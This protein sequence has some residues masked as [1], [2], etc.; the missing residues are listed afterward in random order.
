[1]QKSLSLVQSAEQP[2]LTTL[3]SCHEFVSI[4]EA[5]V[6]DL[7]SAPS[8]PKI[9][10][11]KLCSW[12]NWSSETWAEVSWVNSLWLLTAERPCI[13]CDKF[14]SCEKCGRCLVIQY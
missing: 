6:L 14:H 10:V 13:N 7:I 4:S 9:S 1:M 2:F 5:Q 11:G 12:L 3:N 8:P